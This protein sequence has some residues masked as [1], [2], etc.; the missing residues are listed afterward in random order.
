MMSAVHPSTPVS[1]NTS[2]SY[3]AFGLRITS[4]HELPELER[5]E[6]GETTLSVTWL[7]SV[8]ADSVVDAPP[9]RAGD[10]CIG[11]SF[12]RVAAFSIYPD[13]KQITVKPA[14]GSESVARLPLL[15]P[16]MAIFL[17]LNGRLVLHGSGVACGPG[18][19]AFVGDKGAG[20]STTAAAA[21][22]TG[23]PLVSDDLLACGSSPTGWTA[24]ATYAH[25]KLNTD[26]AGSI[27]LDRA[28]FLPPPHANFPKQQIRLPVHH[29]GLIP[30]RA[31]CVLER[32]HDF[33]LER[34]STELGLAAVL[35]FAYVLR[36]AQLFLTGKEAIE[37]FSRCVAFAQAVPIYTLKLPVTLGQ[38]TS[39]V[40][41]LDAGLTAVGC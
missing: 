6:F 41:R 17:H 27:K 31:M 18:M 13:E 39:A 4:E 16:V 21:V 22:S 3:R 1:P 36:Y 33:A 30:F 38:L 14:A 37:H 7:A 35:R 10:R 32:S 24:E 9:T 23:W 40:S 19:V 12:A 20:K 29:V 25:L 34:R 28:H 15:G 8:A 5:S 26:A 2:F 11:L